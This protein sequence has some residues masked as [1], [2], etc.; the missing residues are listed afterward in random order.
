M[1]AGKHT[2]CITGKMS[3]VRRG[4]VLRDVFESYGIAWMI[5]CGI[6]KGGERKESRERH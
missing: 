6:I 1:G 4:I 2:R 5:R 3:R